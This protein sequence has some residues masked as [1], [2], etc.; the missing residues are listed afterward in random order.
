MKL[1]KTMLAVVLVLSLA[2]SQMACGSSSTVKIVNLIVTELPVALPMA[3]AAIT[4]VGGLN[5]LDVTLVKVG[6]DVKAALG[7]V[8]IL[9]AAYLAHADAATFTKLCDVV[10]AAVNETDGSLLDAAHV[11]DPATRAMVTASLAVLSG[12][13]HVID[14]WLLSQQTPAQIQ[15]RAQAR[16]VKLQQIKS[17]LDV[18]QLDQRAR[19]QGTSF[20]EQYQ[21][22]TALGF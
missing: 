21:K 10:D 15:A 22:L 19:A 13:M 5:G 14:A 7:Q 20:E 12:E 6:P 16:R 17:Y 9:T 2:G 18:P 11:K 4:L 8:Q 1:A 3:E